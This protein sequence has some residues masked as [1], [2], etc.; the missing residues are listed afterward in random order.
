MFGEALLRGEGGAAAAGFCG[1][2]V[3]EVEALAH[4]GFFEVEDHSGEVEEALGVDEE[5][6]R[7]GVSWVA[8]GFDACSVDVDAV[9]LAGLRVEADG[10]AESGA[11]SS[12]DAY[13]EAALLGRDAFLGHCDADALEGVF[14]DLD[15]G[16]SAR[17]LPFS[18][19][20]GH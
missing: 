13:P 4:E 3:D 8:G 16:L 1:V 9:A 7:R 19:E 12:L 11:A 5:S 2:G 17:L 14:G 10:V 18:G 20:E 6:D 15:S